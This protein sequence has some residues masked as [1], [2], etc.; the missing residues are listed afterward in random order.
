MTLV[1]AF[2]LGVTVALLVLA[3]ADTP[4]PPRWRRR[5]PPRPPC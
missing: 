4:W 3:I 5:R 2:L 1:L